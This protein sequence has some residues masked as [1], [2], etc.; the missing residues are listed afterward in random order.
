MADF[1][2]QIAEARKQGHSDDEIVKYLSSKPELA[3]KIQTAQRSGYEAGD[4]LGH[5][6]KA[7]QPSS[8]QQQPI[9]PGIGD[10]FLRTI[11]SDSPLNPMNWPGMV[12]SAFE[13]PFSDASMQEAQRQAD[14]M[15]GRRKPEPFNRGDIGEGL[16]QVVNGGLMYGLGEIPGSKIGAVLKGAAKGAGK[17]ATEMLPIGH[18]PLPKMLGMPEFSVPA[19]IAS[20]I[21]GAGAGRLLGGTP[22]EYL[23]AA[24]GAAAPIVRGA[25]RGGR[26]A[27]SVYDAM[28]QTPGLP[29]S[30]AS[31]FGEG[32]QSGFGPSPALQP[33]PVETGGGHVP[34]YVHPGPSPA[35]MA[36]RIAASRKAEL[37]AAAAKAE[38]GKVI[39]GAE[40]LSKVP[41]QTVKLPGV[42]APATDML[43]PA[44]VAA[45][46]GAETGAGEGAGAGAGAGGGTIRNAA[47]HIDAK[48]SLFATG[49]E[50]ELPGSPTGTRAT[51]YIKQNAQRVYGNS[52]SKLSLEQVQKMGEWL[53][54]H[55][56]LDNMPS[57]APVQ[58]TAAA[59]AGA[60]AGPSIEE[61][62]QQS[63]DAARA[64]RNARLG[65]AQGGVQ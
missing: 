22:G 12:K 20:G 11:T 24:T 1:A 26:T 19:P 39:K 32:A 23:G 40:V 53:A 55:K 64:D 60:A 45:G 58:A 62:L 65:V 29:A 31:G 36:T 52:V 38:A 34:D 41:G 59:G 16:G 25:V 3:P 21:A 27:A 28:H 7:Q 10:R 13:S 6:S 47:P 9:Q 56:T 4:I 50:L 33:S 54:Q 44:P 18:G 14:I 35:E 57:E 17:G 63:V 49:Q 61:Q 2:A 51:D 15:A 43:T 37:E 5:L 8:Q 46:A 48:R 30:T 42:T